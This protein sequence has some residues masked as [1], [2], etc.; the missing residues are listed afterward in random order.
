MTF[1]LAMHGAK[2][3]WMCVDRQLT[4][5]P[6]FKSDKGCKVIEVSGT[7]GVALLGYAGLG[8]SL[9]RTQPSDWMNDLL[10]GKAGLTVEE[11]LG[12]I[13]DAMKL[14]LPAHLA[15]MDGIQAHHLIAP[16][17]IE[18]KPRLYGVQL[19]NRGVGEEPHFVF[20][21]YARTAHG[22]APPRLALAGSGV[23]HFRFDSAWWR[24]TFRL[25]CAYEA[26]RLNP[27]IV[28]DRLAS[29][30]YEVSK[31]DPYVGQK[32]LVIW[33]NNGGAH[34]FYDGT[35]KIE[36]GFGLPTVINGLDFRDI[37]KA[38]MPFFMEQMRAFH[39]TG[40]PIDI[41]AARINEA[42]A[43]ASSRKPRKL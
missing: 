10:V 29:L 16:A 43:K 7:D 24:Q 20:T 21:R 41:D 30:N 9:A 25:V 34:Q 22:G 28:A 3:I 14:D 36:D 18:G 11:C 40:H 32:C 1:V 39:E 31:R 15:R 19:Q 12:I 33:R 38:S 5:S 4:Y 42:L 37:I 27:L 6:T 35:D 23:A 26:G 17:I 8:A 13:A 2:S